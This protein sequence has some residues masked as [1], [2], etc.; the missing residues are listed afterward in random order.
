M[1][2][3]EDFNIECVNSDKFFPWPSPKDLDI[4]TEVSRHIALTSFQLQKK[5]YSSR[6]LSKL[7]K[8]GVLYRY[9]VK[10]SEGNALPSIY[11]AGYTS[12]IIARLPVPRFPRLDVLRIILM[13]N[14]IVISILLQT[15]A[16]I[17]MD[18]RRPVQIITVNNPMGILAAR[19]MSYSR[20]PLY[21]GVRQAIVLIPNKEFA[22]PNLPFRYVLENELEYESFDIQYYNQLPEGLVPV[23]ISFTKREIQETVAL[24]V[25]Q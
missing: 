25:V 8:K 16:T 13:I 6:V 11:T 24:K 20:L 19:N 22:L 4:A 1:G 14:Q 5:G 3:Y 7:V 10:T 9:R 18:I 2:F 12:Q 21:Y 15:E 23:N 17:D